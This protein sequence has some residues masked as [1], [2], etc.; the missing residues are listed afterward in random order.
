MVLMTMYLGR[1]FTLLSLDEIFTQSLFGKNLRKHQ[2]FDYSTDTTLSTDDP[3]A[4]KDQSIQNVP[5]HWIPKFIIDSMYDL[6]TNETGNIAL[7]DSKVHTL[8]YK[9]ANAIIAPTLANHLETFHC[10]KP[11]PTDEHGR[12]SFGQYRHLVEQEIQN[13]EIRD[14]ISISKQPSDKE[15]FDKF[16]NNF[17]LASQVSPIIIQ[18]RIERSSKYPEQNMAMKICEKKQIK[19][20]LSLL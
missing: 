3:R 4:V 2:P 6:V 19:L 11:K 5:A 1:F 15:Y 7:R 20:L 13:D 14:F 16:E 10:M 17:K 12:N 18:E 9:D 8:T